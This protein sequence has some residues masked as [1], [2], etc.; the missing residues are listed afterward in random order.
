[1]EWV[2]LALIVFVVVSAIAATVIWA[3]VWAPTSG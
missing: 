2:F 1:M 3:A